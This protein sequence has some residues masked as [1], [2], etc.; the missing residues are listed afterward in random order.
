[1]IFRVNLREVATHKVVCAMVDALSADEAFD[2]AF[3]EIGCGD[4]F[5]PVSAVPIMERACFGGNCDE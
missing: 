1:M 3:D 4:G 2:E 5:M